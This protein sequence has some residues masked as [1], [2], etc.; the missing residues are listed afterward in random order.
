GGKHADGVQVGRD[1]MDGDSW[2]NSS[3][4]TITNLPRSLIRPLWH[5]G[6]KPPSIDRYQFFFASM[7]IGKVLA[8]TKPW[9]STIVPHLVSLS[10]RN[11]QR[12]FTCLNKR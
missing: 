3:L 4:R 1:W 6:V 8:R 11:S 7:E 2:K 10:M 9:H 5:V 12:V